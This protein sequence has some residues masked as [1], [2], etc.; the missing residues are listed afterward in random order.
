[1]SGFGRCICGE[2]VGGRYV[3]M[4]VEREPSKGILGLENPFALNFTKSVLM[5]VDG[6]RLLFS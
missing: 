3:G 6:S 5:E 2:G 1:M 4:G